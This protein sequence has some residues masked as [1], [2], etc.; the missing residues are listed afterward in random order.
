LSKKKKKKKSSR[1]VLLLQYLGIRTVEMFV[2]MFPI[3]AALVVARAMGHGWYLFNRKHRQRALEHLRASFSEEE[4]S[5]RQARR[6]ARKSCEHFAMLAVETMFTPRLIKPSTWHRFVRLGDIRAAL[7]KML[8]G[9]TTLVLS[10]HFGNWE[11]LAYTMATIGFRINAVARPLDNPYINDHFYGIRTRSG[12]RI[13][14]KKGVSEL[15]EDIIAA[16]QE[17]GFVADQNAGRKGLFVDFF[18]RKASTYKTIAL[19][20][21]RYELPIIVGYARRVGHHYKF[22]LGCQDL[23]VPEDWKDKDD[24]LF[25]VT[26]RF[27]KAIEYLVRKYPDQYLWIHRRWKTRPPEERQEKKKD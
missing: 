11:V 10:G 22:E 19:L 24:E 2:Q 17:I 6:I 3:N 12:L 21:I 20:A 13:L 4:M 15:L 1:Y 8:E 25:Y 5:D 23:I 27:T 18:G 7:D 16:G 14:D 9:K 26:Q